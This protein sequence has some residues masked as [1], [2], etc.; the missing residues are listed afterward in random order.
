MKN[1]QQI[2]RSL[3]HS[4][5]LI[6]S[7][8]SMIGVVATTVLA[9]NATPKAIYILEQEKEKK[10]EL[11]KG[12][13]FKLTW[14]CY[15]PTTIVGVSTI[16]CILGASVLNKRHQASLTSAYALLDQSFK[17]YKKGAKSVFGEEADDKIKAQIA[18]DTY[19]SSD[20][21][22]VYDPDLDDSETVLFW[23]SFSQDFFNSTLTSVINAQYHVN[24]NYSLRGYSTLN[25]LYNFLGLK[26]VEGGDVIGW[27]GD[28]LYESNITW[29]DFSNVLVEMADGVEC[30]IMS[31]AFEPT[32]IESDDPPF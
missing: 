19:I 29:I 28:D 6:L 18:K 12:E 14:R 16:S 7:G 23:D 5:P 31:A 26:E 30:Y 11:T 3:K 4:S 27:W 20:G 10:E 8:I 22:H 24:R 13:I 21:Y 1:V 15:I 9:I 32:I 17:K 25:E 2:K